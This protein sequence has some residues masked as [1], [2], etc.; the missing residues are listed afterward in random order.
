MG[1]LWPRI[2]PLMW[3][4]A[5]EFHTVGTIRTAVFPTSR[6]NSVFGTAKNCKTLMCWILVAVSKTEVP[7]WWK[8]YRPECSHLCL[9]IRGR[10]FHTIV[11][12]CGLGFHKREELRSRGN[13]RGQQFATSSNSRGPNYPSRWRIRG[14][15]Q[16]PE[17]LW[18]RINPRPHRV[19]VSATIP[20]SP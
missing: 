2:P 4:R 19:F 7:H 1:K 14:P 16:G 9:I 8:N 20:P 12:I 13:S 6:V 5:A 15:A 3:V 10:N 18:T 17:E 11:K